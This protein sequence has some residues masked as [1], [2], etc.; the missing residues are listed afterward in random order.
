[1]G[2]AVN[3]AYRPISAGI[4]LLFVAIALDLAGSTLRSLPVLVASFALAIAG[5][6]VAFRGLLEFLGEVF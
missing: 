5:A 2:P 3:R 6:V 4:A 1:V